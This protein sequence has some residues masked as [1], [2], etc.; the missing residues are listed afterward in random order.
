MAKQDCAIRSKEKF[1]KM[2]KDSS[3]SKKKSLD[4]SIKKNEELKLNNNV[5]KAENKELKNEN[6]YLRNI[7]NDNEELLVF[8]DSVG[9][10]RPELVQCIMNLQDCMVSTA[11]IVSLEQIS[12]IS[13]KKNLTLY[14]DETSKF[15]K[16]FEV[17]AVT[18]EDKTSYLLGLREMYSKRA[19][20]V[21]D[22]FKEHHSAE[23]L[24][25]KS[26]ISTICEKLETIME[27]LKRAKDD[28]TQVLL[29]KLA[30]FPDVLT[31][32]NDIILK[33]LLPFDVSDSL[34]IQIL[35][36]LFSAMLV[37]LKRQAADHLPGGNFFKMAEDIQE[38]SSTTLKHNKLPE[39]FFGQLD[40]LM[41]YRPNASTVYNE[42][43]LLFS[44]NKTG[45]WLEDM[46]VEE[47]N[48]LINSC[49][50]EGREL[51]TKL[52][53]RLVEIEKKRLTV[54]MERK[55]ALIAKQIKTLEKN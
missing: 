53:S 7:L 50:K 31:D 9:Q 54:L 55:A 38:E 51:R 4:E 28:S 20:S 46:D 44:H 14:S 12:E 10:Y 39:F 47:R 34:T 23:T 26:H 5:L 29:G 27:F 45:K 35:Q 36:A 11:D 19:D 15:G 33:E 1:M 17:F 8:Y 40:F 42:P 3:E 37:L 18:D 41:K 30:P 16:S 13:E 48:E 21:L 25:K 43:F 52:K 2:L 6:N 49:R 22:T 24:K 32:R